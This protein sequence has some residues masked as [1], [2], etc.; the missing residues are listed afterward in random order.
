[1]PLYGYNKNVD[2]NGKHEV[3]TFNCSFK[4][5][6]LE[7]IGSASD[8]KEAILKA[9]RLTGKTNFDGCYYCS[10]ECSKS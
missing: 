1:M 3:H 4:P 9:K 7:E 5:F 10:R 6:N 2:Q 8:C